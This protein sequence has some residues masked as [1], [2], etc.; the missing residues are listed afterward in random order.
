MRLSVWFY[1]Y[2]CQLRQHFLLLVNMCIILLKI[3]KRDPTKYFIEK[4][5]SNV[6]LNG[7]AGTDSLSYYNNVKF[8][9]VILHV[10]RARVHFFFAHKWFQVCLSNTNNY[11]YC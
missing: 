6:S 5:E 7:N 1:L 11:I 9:L 4:I 3:N 2:V 10:N 8:G